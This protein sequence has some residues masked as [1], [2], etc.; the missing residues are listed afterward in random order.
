MRSLTLLP[1]LGL[2]I[3]AGAFAQAAGQAAPASD[4]IS[5]TALHLD[6]VRSA[7]DQTDPMPELEKLCDEIG[8]RLTGTPAARTAARQVIEHMNT[9]GLQRVHAEA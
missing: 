4:P 8:P 7:A 5:L 9:I 6:M 1:I 2:S 3:C